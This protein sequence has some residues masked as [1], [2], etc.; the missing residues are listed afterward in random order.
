ML[1]VSEAIEFEFTVARVHDPALAYSIVGF[2]AH[3]LEV[4]IWRMQL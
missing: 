4:E 3:A 1:A 2:T